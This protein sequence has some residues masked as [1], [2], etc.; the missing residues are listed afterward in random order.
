MPFEVILYF[1]K[2]V[3]KKRFDL[4]SHLCLNGSLRLLLE[5]S[6]IRC[7]KLYYTR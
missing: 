3:M 6:F 2:G 5:R 1:S 4:D 7:G